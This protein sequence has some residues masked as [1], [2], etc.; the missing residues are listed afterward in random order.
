MLWIG[1]A[2]AANPSV[3]TLRYED[4]I[5]NF[6]E[7]ITD[8]QKF[9]E[10]EPNDKLLAYPKYATVLE[11]KYWTH[12]AMPTHDQVI[13]RWKKPEYA[14]RIEEAMKNEQFVTLL[15]ELGYL[16][17]GRKPMNLDRPL[18]ILSFPKIVY[19]SAFQSDGS[20]G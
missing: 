10:V 11:F 1:L 13:G 18:R 8:I 14:E 19:H 6:A 16:E 4:L 2:E 9:I 17:E 12:E 7:V 3:Y 15:D 5:D 20:A